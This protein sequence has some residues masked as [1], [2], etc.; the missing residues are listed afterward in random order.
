M[1]KN[2]NEQGNILDT[3][4]LFLR[5]LCADDADF[6]VELLNEPGFLQNE[7]DRGVRNTVDA[8]R[9]ILAGPVASYQQLGFGMDLVALRETGE[10]NGDLRPAET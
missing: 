5:H 4:R 7:G 2:G 10:P 1:H 3:E 8:C 6:M 9:S